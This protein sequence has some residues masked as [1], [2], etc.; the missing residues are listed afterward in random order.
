MNIIIIIIFITCKNIYLSLPSC[1]SHVFFCAVCSKFK[2]HFENINNHNRLTNA[3]FNLKYCDMWT[4]FICGF[5]AII[6]VRFVETYTVVDSVDRAESCPAFAPTAE[7]NGGPTAADTCAKPEK[8]LKLPVQ[9]LMRIINIRSVLRD[10]PKVE[11]SRD[12]PKAEPSREALLHRAPI[13]PLRK[14]PKMILI[15]DHRPE[16]SIRQPSQFIMWKQFLSKTLLY[17][18]RCTLFLIFLRMVL[19]KIGAFRISTF[20]LSINYLFRLFYFLVIYMTYEM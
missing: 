18:F 15:L 16:E 19:S 10:Y 7:D 12:H 20:K 2:A 8:Q 6:S 13:E 1:M 4:R 14:R 11:P 5:L 17:T 9:W 3:Q